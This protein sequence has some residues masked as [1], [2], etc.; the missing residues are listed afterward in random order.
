MTK[1]SNVKE[2]QDKRTK[3]EKNIFDKVVSS[4]SYKI[5]IKDEIE[6]G[7]YFD[8]NV[9]IL[10]KKGDI[11]FALDP[12]FG[13]LSKKEV[14]MFLSK[15]Y[16]FN[17]LQNGKHYDDFVGGNSGNIKLGEKFE[18]AIFLLHKNKKSPNEME[19]QMGNT[20]KNFRKIKTG[21][22]DGR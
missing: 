5:S 11:I 18:E 6:S 1:I 10:A 16:S 4:E 15:K 21:K 13:A 8:A 22:T 7:G 9:I 14:K 12:E 3:K 19:T 17:D 2:Y 20:V